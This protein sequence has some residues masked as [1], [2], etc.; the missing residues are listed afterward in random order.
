MYFFF[1]I[2]WIAFVCILCDCLFFVCFVRVIERHCF[3]LLQLHSKYYTNMAMDPSNM[4]M[5]ADLEVEMMTDMY[6][7]QVLLGFIVYLFSL[8]VT[9]N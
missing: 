4:Q 9:P 1:L 6:N 2:K 8:F 7:R 3:D 5:L